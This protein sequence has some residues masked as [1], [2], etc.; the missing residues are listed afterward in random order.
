ME[1]DIYP[2]YPLSVTFCNDGHIAVS[3]I[4]DLIEGKDEE[5]QFYRRYAAGDRSSF[6]SY[7]EGAYT[8]FTY[9]PIN[10]EQ[11]ITTELVLGEELGL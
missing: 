3:N 8:S 7:H 6:R 2:V 10:G 5:V 11:R 9:T 1:C 4:Q